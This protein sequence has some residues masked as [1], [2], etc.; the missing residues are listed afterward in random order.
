MHESTA[1]RGTVTELLLEGPHLILYHRGLLG[2]AEPQQAALQKLRRSLCT[3]E[4]EFVRQR[5]ESRDRVVAALADTTPAERVSRAVRTALDGVAAADAMWLV[6]L[7][8]SR[9]DALALLTQPQRAQL[10]VLRDHWARETAAMIDEATRPGQR[11]HPGTQIP[12]R[13]PG[14]VVDETTLLPY[15]EALHGPTMHISIPPPR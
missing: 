12:V 15:C 6:A 7:V 11:G 9:R 10:V 1:A 14:M 2:L 13:V 4:V 5:N 3:T 8:Q